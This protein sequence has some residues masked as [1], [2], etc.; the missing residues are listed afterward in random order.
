MRILR[1]RPQRELPHSAAVLREHRARLHRV[2]DQPLIDDVILHHHLGSFECGVGI[3]A[4]H[5]PVEADVVGDIGVKLR[6]SRF[7]CFEGIDGD[8]QRLVVDIDR[9]GGI[10]RLIAIGCDDDRDGVSDVADCVDCDRRIGWRFRIRTGDDPCARDRAEAG[11]LHLLAGVHAEDAGHRGGFLCIN[12][13]DLCVRVR[14]SHHGHVDHAGENEVVG[15]FGLAGDEPRIFAA[16]D[17][18]SENA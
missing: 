1:R 7:R 11:V 3:A 13:L 16:F 6:R 2:R 8:R 5:H 4:V 14:R 10:A 12:T 9:V 15:V 18:G 17:S